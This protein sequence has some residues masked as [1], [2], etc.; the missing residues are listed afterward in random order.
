M[1]KDFLDFASPARKG[2][3]LT[4]LRFQEHHM[5]SSY[6]LL[7]QQKNIYCRVVRYSDGIVSVGNL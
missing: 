3:G 6:I 5:H 2:Q 1:D 7:T 4:A